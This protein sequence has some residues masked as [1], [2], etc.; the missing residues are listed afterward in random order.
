MTTRG[1][2]S[3]VL[4][5]SLLGCGSSASTNRAATTPPQQ[6]V[7]VAAPAPQAPDPMAAEA[8]SFDVELASYET[9]YKTRGRYRGR[10]HNVELAATKVDGTIIPAHSVFSFNDTVGERTR[11][12]GF[13]L[14]PV[15]N[16][17]QITDGMG[18]GVCQIA[19][20]IFAA[21]LY[22]GLD[23]IEQ[24][25]HSRPSTYIELALDATVVYPLVDLKISNPYD[26]PVMIRASAERG[27]VHVS[28]LGRERIREVEVV[29]EVLSRAGFPTRT[30]EDATLPAGSSVTD[31]EGIRGA[32]VRRVRIVREAAG[33]VEHEETVS[34]PPTE[35]IVRV[36]TGSVLATRGATRF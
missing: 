9:R 34:Y 12:A 11:R 22:G 36:G 25:P 2:L 35:R 18:G 19:S 14:A 31:Q 6:E 4:G 27:Q 16:D 26:F 30:I 33:S 13:R 20:T 5:V 29:R 3:V 32:R 24:R 17:G 15:I 10:A 8:P 21:S 23:P 7:V 28:L 1:W